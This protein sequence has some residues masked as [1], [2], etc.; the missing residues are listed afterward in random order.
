MW[1]K[2]HCMSSEMLS[3]SQ[4]FES[5]LQREWTCSPSLLILVSRVCMYSVVFGCK[6][7]MIGL[8]VSLLLEWS[9]RPGAEEHLIIFTVTFT[10]LS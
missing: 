6:S 5:A 9:S 7:A 10:V 1:W 2:G 3:I 4:V 8:S